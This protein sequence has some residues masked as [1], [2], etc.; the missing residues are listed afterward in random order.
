[1]I[2]KGFNVTQ[3]LHWHISGCQGVWNHHAKG[4]WLLE[5]L[6]PCDLMG[7]LGSWNIDGPKH[8]KK[9]FTNLDKSFKIDDILQF[10]WDFMFWH[11]V[12][13]GF[14]G[15]DKLRVFFL[16]ICCFWEKMPGIWPSKSDVGDVWSWIFGARE[17]GNVLV[18]ANGKLVVGDGILWIPLIKDPF[19]KVILGIQ[20]TR[21]QATH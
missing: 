4:P 18:S 3:L 2:P 13:L 6:L 20:T 10:V 9:N 11:A 17:V 19:H 8:K 7:M 14:R 16:D 5:M 21:T 15:L 12:S 1:M